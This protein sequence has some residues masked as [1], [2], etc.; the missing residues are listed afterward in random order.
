MKLKPTH[1]EFFEALAK[2]CDR[3]AAQM[4]GVICIEFQDNLLADDEPG[5]FA[6][7][8]TA[9]VT[10]EYCLTQVKQDSGAHTVRFHDPN[11][12]GTRELYI[13]CR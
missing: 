11:D 6:K 3:H 7:K 8:G 4:E 12:T 10:Q 5:T 9:E 2:L 1:R 13:D